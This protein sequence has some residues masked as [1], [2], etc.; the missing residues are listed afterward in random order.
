MAIIKFLQIKFSTIKI[1]MLL[2]TISINLLFYLS[3]FKMNKNNNMTSQA[4]IEY[5]SSVNILILLILP[6]FL[7]F[8]NALPKISITEIFTFGKRTFV[9]YY[10][11][12]KIVISLLLFGTTLI[13][14]FLISYVFI[15]NKKTLDSIFIIYCLTFFEGFLIVALINQI[16]DAL[17]NIPIISIVIT[18][19]VFFIDSY[20]LNQKFH[21]SL[22]WNSTFGSIYTNSIY[23][24][25]F[26]QFILCGIIILLW[27]IYCL[28]ALRKDVIH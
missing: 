25:I 2:F 27:C 9:I 23:F 18:Y 20:I 19:C 10:T 3:F 26:N 13:S 5:M 28:I 8:F 21:F 16:V 17:F 22:F 7:V 24:D 14:V 6:L 1:K 12:S 15:H 4:F 11:F